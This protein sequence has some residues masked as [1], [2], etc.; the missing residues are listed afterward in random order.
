MLVYVR[1]LAKKGI[2]ICSTIHSPTP[3]AF[4]LFDRLI[5]LLRGKVIY[6]GENGT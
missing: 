2:T 4:S 3:F 6:F 1:R 5:M